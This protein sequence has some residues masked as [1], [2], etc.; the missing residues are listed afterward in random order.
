MMN[1]ISYVTHGFGKPAERLTIREA[2]Q[3]FAENYWPEP[4][5]ITDL[6]VIGENCR[7]TAQFGVVNGTNTYRIGWDEDTGGFAISLV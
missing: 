4:R 5:Q 2:A 1:A 3:M 6:N 7:L